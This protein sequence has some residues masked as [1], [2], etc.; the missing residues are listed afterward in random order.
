MPPIINKNKCNGCMNC[1]TICPVDAFGRQ[2]KGAAYPQVRFPDECWH[3]N[4][5]VLECPTKACTLRVPL[6]A[7]MLFVDAPKKDKA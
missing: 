3:C 4:S 2:E 1:V 6:P 5:C 7:T